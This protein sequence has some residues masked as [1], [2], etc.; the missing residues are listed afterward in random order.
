VLA[1]LN[2]K[3]TS[4]TVVTIWG[5]IAI[6]TVVVKDYKGLYVQRV[7]LGFVEAMVGPIFV[8]VTAL[9]YKPQEQATRLGVWY[10]ATGMFNMFSGAINYGLGSTGNAH[11]WKYM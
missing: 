10:S 11:A 3:Y 7:A 1:R 2:I 6:L 4:G 9:W 5:L 8:H